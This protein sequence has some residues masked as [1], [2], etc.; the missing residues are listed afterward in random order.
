MTVVSAQ[1][2]PWA[3]RC[4]L[5]ESPRWHAGWWWWIDAAVGAVFRVDPQADSGSHTTIRPWWVAGGRVSLVHPAAPEGVL[6]ARG[7]VLQVC[8]DGAAG[9]RP[10]QG[11]G[12]CAPTSGAAGDGPG[13]AARLGPR[14]AE[15]DVPAGWLLN[16]GTAG[17]GG[18]LYIGVVHPQRDPAAGYLQYVRSDGTLGARVPG[19]GLSNGL[20]LDPAGSVL[21]HA[22]STRRLIHAHRLDGRGEVTGSAVHLRFD[23]DDGMPDG[24]ATDAAGGLWV[25]MYGASQVRR[26]APDGELDLV[27]AVP[28]PQVT[29][30]A[31]G[32]A[33]GRDVLITTAREG[34]DER[35]AA[36]EP[37]A[38]RLFSARSPHAGRPV[39]PVRVGSGE[40]PG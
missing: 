28:T 32:G 40:A 14:L 20:A 22:D 39:L 17:P 37:L 29:S 13:M 27:V 8:L 18:G 33:D 25:A 10:E 34:Y 38:G 35:R 1:P 26:Y 19:I 2:V 12:R 23:P 7:P 3:E 15:L 9:G 16:D 21:Y 11:H 4:E 5:A 6:V 30:V 31:L 24:L 36:A